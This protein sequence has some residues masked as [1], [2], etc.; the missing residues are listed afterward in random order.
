[1]AETRSA[2]SG[3]KPKSRT[4]TNGRSGFEDLREMHSDDLEFGIGAPSLEMLS[5]LK[6]LLAEATKLRMVSSLFNRQ[7]VSYIKS[8]GKRSN[9][10]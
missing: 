2:A 5:K 4:A 7:F 3:L 1:M 6:P 9:F 10:L 8:Y